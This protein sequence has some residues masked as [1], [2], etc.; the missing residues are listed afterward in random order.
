MTAPLNLELIHQE[1][2]TA[3][4]LLAILAEGAREPTAA[5]KR[6]DAFLAARTAYSDEISKLIAERKRH[7]TSRGELM[8][9][10]EEHAAL[11]TRERGEHDATLRADRERSEAEIAAKRL[12]LG[13]LAAHL[14]VAQAEAARAISENAALRADLVRKTEKVDQILTAVGG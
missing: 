13:K 4:D 6:L 3:Y 12:E 5:K 2:K 7:E 11:L 14:T 10:R 1:V 9:A 8:R